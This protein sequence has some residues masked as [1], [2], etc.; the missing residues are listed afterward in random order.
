MA[1]FDISAE[2]IYYQGNQLSSQHKS[3]LNWIQTE[4]YIK[5]SNNRQELNFAGHQHD[6]KRHKEIIFVAKLFSGNK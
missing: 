2:C 1:I 3:N 6:E 5:I 4:K